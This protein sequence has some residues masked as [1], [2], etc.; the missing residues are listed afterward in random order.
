[1]GLILPPNYPLTHWSTYCLSTHLHL[2]CHLLSV[3]QSVCPS[4]YLSGAHPCTYLPI[5]LPVYPFTHLPTQF[6]SP[7][8]LP[9]HPPMVMNMHGWMVS[10]WMMDGWMV[11]GWMIDR[12]LDA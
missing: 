12:W 4:V 5:G 7:F 11:N 2:P 8:H 3:G 10:G 9:I 1:M 6:S